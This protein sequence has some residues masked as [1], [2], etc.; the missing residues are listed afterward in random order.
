MA[1][2]AWLAGGMRRVSGA[3][4]FAQANPGKR[5]GLDPRGPG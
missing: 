4:L 1:P 3:V 5:G 2:R